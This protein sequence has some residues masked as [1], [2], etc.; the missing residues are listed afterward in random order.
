M[1]RIQV[2]A[3]SIVLFFS[4]SIKQQAPTWVVKVKRELIYQASFAATPSLHRP[5]FFSSFFFFLIFL[6]IFVLLSRPFPSVIGT[7]FDWQR[8][9]AAPR[10]NRDRSLALVQKVSVS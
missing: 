1:R 4:K 7:R 10:A 8:L 3:V 2:C 6:I 5:T 9:S